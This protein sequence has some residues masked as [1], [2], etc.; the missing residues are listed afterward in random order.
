MLPPD[1]FIGKISGRGV[2][3][4]GEDFLLGGVDEVLSF[5]ICRPPNSVG[6]CEGRADSVAGEVGVETEEGA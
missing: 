1:S 5:L 6:D 2:V 4:K 3:V